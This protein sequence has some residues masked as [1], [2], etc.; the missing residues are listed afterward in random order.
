[1]RQT[2]I[3]SLLLI[4]LMVVTLFSTA[5]KRVEDKE[6]VLYIHITYAG[7]GYKFV[8]DLAAKYTEIYGKEVD[9]TATNVGELV[10]TKLKAGKKNNN[11]DLFMA[12]DQMFDL[13]AMGKNALPGYDSIFADLSD[14]YNSY[15][16]NSDVKIKDFIRAETV[17]FY[18]VNGSLY[19]IPYIE[20]V[21][22]LV[23]NETIFKQY[24]ITQVPRTTDE[25]I[26]VCEVL[27]GKIPAFTYAGKYDYWKNVYMAWWAQYEGMDNIDL[28][29]EGK[30]STGMYSVN[31]YKQAGRL[32]ALEVLEELLSP[33]NGYS[34]RNA[35][36]YEFTEAQVY[37]LEGNAAMMPN[38]DWLENEMAA[39]FSEDN[40]NIKM[41]RTP[42]ISKLGE[43]LGISEQQLRDVID[44]VDGVSETKPDVSDNVI[45]AVEDA[46]II[47]MG[48]SNAAPAFIPV[49]S[50]AVDMAKDFLRLMYSPTGAEIVMRATGGVVL[51]V[52]YDY[53]NT[54]GYNDLSV[55][56]Q[57]KLEITS[58]V[59]Y[60]FESRKNPMFYAGGLTSFFVDSGC[61]EK[62]LGTNSEKDR[63]TAK[64]LYQADIEYYSTRWDSIMSQAG[65]S[66]D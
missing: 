36:T 59:N 23:Y 3:V 25:L 35:N 2:K 39:N 19:T 37:Y 14:V 10:R 30:D 41:M 49:Y 58:K 8:E 5:C 64:A 7:N 65:V 9:V 13:V 16:Y 55:F 57:S 18:D 33:D 54:E 45:K 61:L 26:E 62:N 31:C 66:N 32:Y 15:G 40:L 47:Q 50:N 38:G 43:K 27:K 63:T 56:Q 60:V 24:G 46:R 48:G 11:V 12:I 6:D 42:I 52:N 53:S 22:G 51:P 44:Y 34:D 4:L 28:F 29:F 20:N 21:M 1:M 17:E